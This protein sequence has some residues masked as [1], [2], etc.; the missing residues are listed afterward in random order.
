MD[1]QT[2]TEQHACSSSEDQNI[3]AGEL[4]AVDLGDSLRPVDLNDDTFGK[5][6]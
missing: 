5:C 4:T 1:F 2:P 6:G 3:D